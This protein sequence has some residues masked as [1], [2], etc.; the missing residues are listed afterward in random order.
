[1]GKAGSDLAE[2]NRKFDA[3]TCAVQEERWAASAREAAQEE[4]HAVI[5]RLRLSSEPKL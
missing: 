2:L 3:Y 1:M 4:L 5:A